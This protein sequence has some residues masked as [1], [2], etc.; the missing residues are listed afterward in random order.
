MF[1]Y[2]FRQRGLVWHS[3]D[4]ISLNSQCI[5][6]IFEITDKVVRRNKFEMDNGNLMLSLNKGEEK[7]S[8]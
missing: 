2:Y 5:I 7:Y 4:S 3:S 6:I 1:V 8:N